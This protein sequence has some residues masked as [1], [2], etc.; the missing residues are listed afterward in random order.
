MNINRLIDIR[1]TPQYASFMESIEWQV[2][3]YKKSK[4]FIKKLPFLHLYVG[5]MLHSKHQLTSL[6]I[7]KIKKQYQLIYFSYE[8]FVIEKAVSGRIYW[9]QNHNS[10]KLIPTKTLWINLTKD[11]LDLLQ[12]L[13]AKT[14]YNLNRADKRLGFE[15][16]DGDIITN[17][18]L[19]KIIDL[20]SKNNPYNKLFPAPKNEFINLLKTFG[21]QSFLIRSFEKNNS[22]KTLAFCLILCSPNM[23]FY[24]HNGS[25]IL[26]RQLFA[27]TF[28]VWQAIKESKKR[29]LQIFD[30]EGLFDERFPKLNINWK[31]FTKFKES[32]IKI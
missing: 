23:A 10:H 31:G 5:K 27:P 2:I 29:K 19:S 17:D 4:I 12:N 26:G 8:P 21:N 14:R 3:D 15:T 6:E 22:S 1:Q 18:I 32:F 11:Y 16:I 7:N 30:F 9:K 24:W 20:W 25:N 13:K 28:C